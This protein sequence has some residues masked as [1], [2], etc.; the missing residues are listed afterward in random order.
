MNL[1]AYFAFVIGSYL[2]LINL[3]YLLN[4]SHYKKF[5]SDFGGSE[6]VTYLSGIMSLIFGLVIV[7]GHNVWVYSWPVLVTMVGWIAL[8]QGAGRLIFPEHT[9]KYTKHLH[10][11]EGYWLISIIWLLV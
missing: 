4:T 11:R 9:G 6:P 1:S 3:A 8:I 5:V 10:S 7:T 2:V